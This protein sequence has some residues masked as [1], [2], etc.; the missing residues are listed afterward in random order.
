MNY[1]DLK[2]AIEVFRE[3]PKEIAPNTVAHF[4][5][6]PFFITASREKDTFT[7]CVE[8]YK[9]EIPF[10]LINNIRDF[11]TAVKRFK[12]GHP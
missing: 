11:F 4:G 5:Y 1:N 7:L 3:N 10:E 9:F 12:Y 6:H 2:A 8:D